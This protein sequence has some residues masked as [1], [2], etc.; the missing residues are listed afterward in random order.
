MEDRPLLSTFAVTSTDDA[1]PGSFRQAILDAESSSSHDTITFAIPGD[2]VQTIT[3]ATALPTITKS[4]LLDGWSQPG[5]AGTPLIELRGN[6]TIPQGLEITGSDVQVRG[7]A[8][9]GFSDGPAIEIAGPDAA[10]N[11]IYGNILGVDSSGTFSS[12]NGNGIVVRTGAHDNIIGSN[13]DGQNDAQE[14]NVIDGNSDTGI[15]VASG[16]PDDSAGMKLGDA[17]NSLALNGSASIEGGELQFSHVYDWQP[18]AGSAFTTEPVDITRFSSRFQFKTTDPAGGGFTFTIQRAGSQ[19]LGSA[20]GGLGYQGIVPSAAV[21][22]DLANDSGE[23]D[24]STGLYLDGAAPTSAGSIDL[25][26]TGIDLTSADVFEAVVSYDGATL[27]VTITDTQTGA[28]ASQSYP[29]DLVGTVG[30]ATA[31]VGFTGATENGTAHEDI[32]NWTYSAHAGDPIDNR[33][34]G[35]SIFG[36]GRDTPTPESELQFDGSN[37]VRLPDNLISTFLAAET[38]EGWFQTTEGGVILGYEIADPSSDQS[39][40][41][42]P[43]LYVGTDGKLYGDG[44]ISSP[45][46]VADGRWHQFALV[47]DRPSLTWTVYLD[48]Q[49]VGSGQGDWYSWAFNQ[50]GTGYTKYRFGTPN[51]NPWYGFQG[52]I[53]D[54]RIWSVERSADQIRKDMTTAASGTEPGLEAYYPF[55]EGQ[56]LTAHDA[57]P[58]HRDAT[59]ETFGGSDPAWVTTGMAP[60]IDLG[61]DGVTYPSTSPRQGPNRLQN[62]PVIASTDNHRI[63]G[64]LDGAAATTYHIEFFA[65]SGRNPGDSGDAEVFLQSIAA[66]TDNSGVALFDVPYT[67]VDGKPAISATATDPDGNTSEVSA[68]RRPISLDVAQD[69]IHQRDLGPI[70]FTAAAGTAV[71]VVDPEADPIPR[72]EL[73]LTASAGTLTLSGTAGLSGAG[74]G[75]GSLDYIGLASDLTAALE[76]M[77]F[78]PPPGF[79]GQVMVDISAALPGQ[80]PVTAR[81]TV[82]YGAYLVTTTADSGP[83]SLRQAILDANHAPGADTIAFAIA[84]DGVQTIQLQSELPAITDG[85]LLDGWSQPGFATAPLI[86]IRG[87]SALRYGLKITGSNV[88]VRGLAIDGFS[89]GAAVQIDGLGAS[90]DWIHG[91][92]LGVDPSGAFSLPNKNGIVIRGGAHDNTIGTTGAG[93]YDA[94]DANVIEGNTGTGVV[95]GGFGES[96]NGLALNGSA[97][98]QDGRIRLTDGAYNEAGSAFA[99]QPIDVTHFSTTFRFKLTNATAD[100]F[101]FTIQGNSASSLGGGASGLGYEGIGSSVAVKFDLFNNS[102]EGIDSTGLFVDGASPSEP[103]SID[104]SGTGIDLHSGAIFDATVN[105]DGVTLA[106]TIADTRTGA[107]A[108][109]S[110][111]VDIPGT[112]GGTTAYVG[113]TGGTGGAT[114]VQDILSWNGVLPANDPVNN[115]ITGNAIFDNGHDT[116]T[117]DGKLRF[118]GS[119][120]VSLPND[121]VR[122]YESAETVEAWFQT[123]T[124]GVILGYQTSDPSSYPYNGYVPAL[125]VGTDGRLYGELWNGGINQATS[126]GPVNDGRWHHVGLVVDGQAGTESLYLDGLLVGSVS[127]SAQNFGGSFD[128][129]GTG[130]TDGWPAAPGGWFGFQGQIDDVQIRSVVRSADEIQHD[131]STAATGTEPGL[132]AYYKFDEGQGATAFDATANHRDAALATTGTDLPA[133]VGRSGLAIDL[134]G[135]GVTYNAPAPRQGPNNL[136]NYPIVVATADGRYRGWLSGSLLDSAYHIEFFAGA[137]AGQAQDYL[138]SLEVTT[139]GA[140]QAVFDV[141]FAPPADEPVISAT[142]TDPSGNTS[143]ISEARR[144][145]VL[146]VAQS[147]FHSRDVVPI[148]FAAADNTAITVIDPDGDPLPSIELSVSA[149]A[150]TLTLSGTSRLVGSGNG[151]GALD[152]LGTASDL[153]AAL[154]GMRYEPPPGFTGQVTVSLVVQAQGQSPLA[155]ELTLGYGPYFVTTTADNGPGSLRQAILDANNAPGLD[156]IAFAIP[157]GG[158]QTITPVKELPAITDPVLIDGTSQPGYA[159]TPLIELRGQAGGAADGLTITGSG[160]T[161]RGLSIDGF[162]SGS[163][164]ILSGPSAVDN[165]IEANFIGVD[166]TGSHAEPN[167]HGVSISGG[168]HDNAIGGTTAGAGNLIA[169]DTGSG[170][171][172]TDA[173][174][175]GNSIVGNRIF[176]TSPDTPTPDGILR[177]DGSGS[178]V[179]VPPFPLG[180]A[181]TFEAWVESDNVHANFARIFDFGNAS[182]GNNIILFWNGGSGQMGLGDNDQYGNWNYFVTDQQFPERRRVYVAAVI[183]GQGSGSIYWDGQLIK[184]GSLPA[185]PTLTR[186]NQYLARSNWSSDSAFTG[187]MDEVRI[188]SAA[189][190]A[191]EIQDDGNHALSGDEPGLEAYYRFDEGQGTTAFDLTSHHR[192]ATLASNGGSLPTWSTEATLPAWAP[193]AIDLSGDGPTPNPIGPWQGPGGA[194]VRLDGSDYVSLP[195]DLIR[196]YRNAE[197]I[198]AWFQT[199]SGG[200]ILGYQGGSP[201]SGQP[202]G[203]VPALYVGTDGLLHGDLYWDGSQSPITSRGPVNDGAWHHVALVVDNS[204]PSQ[205][206][207]LDGARLGSVSNVVADFGGSFNQIGTGYTQYWPNTNGGWFGFRGQI[208]DV[209]IWSV[210][211]SADE[212]SQDMSAVATG[213]EPSL[214]A[215]YKFDEGQGTTDHD[216]TANHR[217]A[218]IVLPQ[219]PNHLQSYPIVV[220]TADG[221]YRGWLGGSLPDSSY[222]IEFFAGAAIG[223]AEVYLGSLEVTTDDS[224]QAAFDVPYLPPADKPFVSATA[225]DPEGN[226]SE[227]S[228]SPRPIALDVGQSK[229]HRR[230]A[231]AIPFTAADRSEIAVVDPDADPYPTVQLTV[232]ASAGTLTLSGTA[233]LTGTGNGT[234]ALQYV[235]SAADLDA[236]LAGMQLTPPPGFSGIVTVGVAVAADGQLPLTATLHLE[237]GPYFVTTTADSGPGSLRQAILDANAAPGLD[238]IAFAIAGSGVQTISPTTPL[239]AITDPLLID[240]YSQPGY[241]GTPLIELSGQAAGTGDGLTITASGS[242]IRGLAIDDFAGT[243]IVLSGADATGDAII[244]NDI[245]TDPSGLEARPNGLGIAI[246]GGAHDNTVGGTIADGNLISGNAGSGVVV[247]GDSSVGNRI[248]GNRIFANGHVTPTP[249]GALRFDGSNWVN[250]PN[251]LIDSFA[252]SET[253]EAWFQTQ[254]GGVILGYQTYGYPTYPSFGAIPALYVGTDG[255]LY[256]GFSGS[257]QIG[258]DRFVADGRWHHAALVVD[259]GTRTLSLYV[260]GQLV[261]SI[262]GTPSHIVAYV[263]QIGIGF[264]DSW[265]ATPGGWYGF[266]G[267]ID[268]VRIWSQARSAGEIQH[269]MTTAAK[270]TEPGLEL[271]YPF[272]VR[273]WTTALDATAHHRD[274]T[275]ASSSGSNPTWVTGSVQSIDLGGASIFPDGHEAL[276]FDGSGSYVQLPSFD[277]GGPFTVEAWVES[278]NVHASWARIIDFGEDVWHNSIAL[279][280]V[281]DTGVM[282]L[283][284]YDAAGAAYAITT[285]AVFPQGQWVHVAASI[286]SQGNAAIYW[287][288]ELVAAGSIGVPPVE[289]RTNQYVARSEYAPDSPFT[290]AIDELEIWNAARTADQIRADMT[291]VPSGSE[292]GLA[293]YYGFN[294]GARTIAHDAT[295]HHRDAALATNGGNLPT[296]ILA[297][298]IDQGADGVTYNAAAPRRGPNNLENYPIIATTDGGRLQGWLSGLPATTYHLEFFASAAHSPTGSGE[299]EVFLAATDVTSDG[300]GVAIFDIPYAP[301]EGRPWISATATDPLGNTS[302]VSPARRVTLSGLGPQLRFRQVA[303]VVFSTGTGRALDLADPDAGPVPTYAELTLSV[304]GGALTLGGT[305]GLSG[306]GNGTASLDYRGT[307]DDLNAALNGLRFDPPAAIASV[308]KFTVTVS[309]PG[310][311]ETQSATSVIRSGPWLVTNTND[312]GDG[313]L[314]W[315]I[316]QANADP[317]LDGIAFAIPGAGVQTIAPASPLPAI[318]DPLFL[319]GT[320]QPGYAGTPLIELSGQAAGTADGLTITGSGT[321]VRG[322]AIDDFASGA[323]I[324]LSGSSASGNVIASNVLGADLAGTQAAPNDYGIRILG[325]AHDNLIGGNDRADGNVI[326]YHTGPGIVVT[327]NDSVGNRIGGNKIYADARERPAGLS[328]DGSNYLRLPDNLIG[329]LAPVETFEARFRTN[330]GGVILGYQS[331]D[332]SAN[333]ASGWIPALFVGTDGRLYGSIWSVAYGLMSSS[334]AVNDGRWHTVALAVNGASQTQSLYL[335]GTLIG[336]GLGQFQD[337][338]GRFNQVGTGYTASYYHNTNSGWFGFHGQID[339]VRIWSVPRSAGDVQYDS[340]HALTGFEPGLEAYY[341]FDEGQGLTAHDATPNHRD[342]TLA[343]T[344]GSLP[345]WFGQA[346]DLG[347]DGVTA[348]ASAPRQGPNNLQNYPIVLTTADGRVRGWLGGSLPNAHYDLEFFASANFGAY[349]SGE[350]EVYLGA[351]EVTTDALGQAVFD[352]PYKAPAG[353]QIVTATA[354]DPNGDTSEISS[355]RE[356]KLSVS[357]AYVRFV[358][359]S[360]VALSPATG[361]ALVLEDPGAGPLDPAWDLSLSVASGSLTLATTAGLSGTG[362]GTGSLHY[363]GGL[364]ELN[365]ALDGLWFTPAADSPGKVYLSIAAQSAGARSLAGRVVLTDGLCSVTTTAN[366]GEGSLRQAIIDAI[367]TPGAATIGFAIAGPGAQTISPATPLPILPAGLVIDGTTQPGYAGTPLIELDGQSAG[368]ADGLT[369]MR[370]GITIRGLAIDDFGSGA[371]ILISGP[372]ATGDLIE[373]NNIGTDPT[374]TLPKPNATGITIDGNARDNTIGGTSAAAGNLI[375]FNAGS[376]IVVV[377]DSSVGNRILGNRI[378][379]NSQAQHAGL[380]FDGSAAFVQLP[381]FPLGGAMTFEEWVS[382]DNVSAPWSRIFDFSDGPDNHEIDLAWQ[383]QTGTMS[384]GIQDQNDNWSG[385]TTSNV[386][387]QNRWVHVA[388]TID[389]QGNAVLYWDGVDEA[390]GL[391][392]VPPVLSRSQMYLGWSNWG[393]LTFAGGIHD[394]AIWSG[395]RTADQIKVDMTN[396]PTGSEPGLEAYYPLDD[397]QGGIA[398]DA[399]PNHRDAMLGTQSG[400]SLPTWREIP[401]QAIDLNGDGFTTNSPSPR[402]GPNNLQNYPVVVTTA[403]G[404]FQGWLEGSQPDARY[405]VDFFAS[406]GYARWGAGEA[407]NY[408]GSL[409][410]TTDSAGQ[411]VF[412]VPYT[413][414]ADQPVVTATA[415]DPSGNT[416]ELSARRRNTS[417]KAPTAYI[418]VTPGSSTALAAAPGDSIALQDPEAGP[419][420]PVWDLS[421]SVAAGTLSFSTMAGLVGTGNGTA[422]LHYRGGLIELNA[423]LAGLEFTAPP[424]FHGTISLLVTA[425]PDGLAPIESQLSL[426]DGEFSVTTT[427]DSGP[428]SL[429]QAILDADATG[430]SA[431]ITFGIPGTGAQTITLASP[432]PAITGAVLIDGTSQPG[433]AGTPL[434]ELSGRNAGPSD[435]IV[436]TGSSATI[437]GLAI[438][439]FISGAGILITGTAATGNAIGANFIG[440]DSSGT[441]AQP[442]LFGVEMSDG[443]HDNTIGGTAAGV[444]N[445]IIDNLGSEVA[446]TGAGSVRNRIL[447]NRIFAYGQHPLAGVNFDGSGSYVQL[448]SFPLGGPMTVEAWVESDNVHAS[449]ARVLDFGVPYGGN[450]ILFTWYWTTGQMFWG[451]NDQSG[452]WHN[453]LTTAVFPQGRWVYVAATVDAEGNG[454]IYWDGQQ[455]ASG[456]VG[457]APVESRPDQYLARSNWSY[458]SAF[459]GS[460]DEVKIWSGARTPD[461]I[462]AD[463][464]ATPSGSDPNLVAY[465]PLDEGAGT[466]VHDASGNQ[467]DGAL[468][469]I[470]ASNPVWGTTTDHAIDLVGGRPTARTPSPPQGTNNPQNA[471]VIVTTADGQLQGWLSGSLPSSRYHIELF[472]SAGAGPDGSGEAEAYL[473]SLEVTT[474]ATGQAVFDIPFTAPADKPIVSAT[475]TDPSGNTSELS[476]LRQA[477]V[478]QP[479]RTL[480]PVSGTDLVFS[481]ATGDPFVLADPDAGPLGALPA[482]ELSLSVSDGALTLSGTTGLTGTGNGTDS[483][484]YQGTIPALN[485]ALDGLRYTREPGFHGLATLSLAAHSAD[486][487]PLEGKL[488]IGF[489]QVTSTADGGPG[490]LRQAILDADASASLGTIEFD[491]PGTGVHTIAPLLPLPP[492]TASELIDGFTQPGYSGTP[493]VELSG[494]TVGGGDGLTIT[495]SGAT[496]RGLAIDGFTAGSAIVISGPGAFGNVIQANVLGAGLVGV[497]AAPNFHGVQIEGGAHDNTVGGTGPADGNLIADDLGSGVVVTGTG[498]ADDRIEGNRIFV[499]APAKHAGLEFDGSGAFV[500]L[501]SFTLGGPVTLEAS[502]ESDDIQAS[503]TRIFNFGDDPGSH[504]LLLTWVGVSGKMAL[505]DEGTSGWG[506][507][508]TSSV[509]PQGRW[510]HVAATIDT[511]GDGVIY[512]NGVPVASGPV[513]VPLALS[514]SRMYLGRS[515]YPADTPFAGAMHDVA[516]WSDARTAD[517][518]RNDMSNP[519]SGSEP[520]LVAYYPLNEEQGRTLHDF[521]SNHYDATLVAGSGN[522]PNWQALGAREI[523]FGGGE[524]TPSA[525]ASS[526]GPNNLQNYPVVLTTADG[527]LRGWLGA[528][529]PN[530][531]Y[532]LEFFAG[533]EPGQA[534]ILLGSLEVTTDASGQAVF[535]VPFVPPAG[536]PVVSATATDPSGDTSEVSGPRRPTLAIPAQSVPRISGGSLV[537]SAAT[538]NAFAL[539]DPDAGPLDPTWDLSLSVDAGTLSLAGT[540]GLSGT[541]DGTDSL[542]Y[543]GTLAALNT[544]L[545]GLRYTW[546]AGFAGLATVSGAARSDGATTLHGQVV[547]DFLPVTTTA[548]S[549]PGSLR[550]AITDADAATTPAVI[551]F[552]IPGG[553][554]H[555]I[556]PLTPLPP[557]S[558][559]VLIDGFSQPGYT[560][561][562]LI[563]LDGR[564]AGVSE[565]LT[566]AGTNVAFSGLAIDGFAFPASGPGTVKI[567]SGPLPPPGSAGQQNGVDIYRFDLATDERLVARVRAR[568][569]SA[570]LS[571]VD[572]QGRLLVQ[573]DGASSSSQDA[574]IDQHL[575]AGTYFLT[576]AST[577][578]AGDYALSASLAPASAPFQPIN[579]GPRAWYDQNLS[580]TIGDFNGD[581]IPDLA[582]YD[583]VHLGRGDGTF[584]PPRAGLGIPYKAR[585]DTGMI[586]GEFDGDGKL[587]LAVVDSQDN[588]VWVLLGNGDGTFRQAR[589]YFVGQNPISLG[590]GDFDG[591]GT[592]DLAVVNFT[593]RDISVLLG[594]GDGT[595]KPEQRIGSGGYLPGVGSWYPFIIAPG[596]FSGHSKL[597]LVFDYGILAGNGDGTFQFKGFL[598]APAF[599]WSLAV[600]DF[601]GD[602]RLDV[603]AALAG[604]GAEYQ[605]GHLVAVLLGNGDGTFQPAQILDTGSGSIP[606]SVVAGD[607][608]GDGKLDL[609]IADAGTG[610]ISVFL[611]NGDGTFQPERR[612]AAGVH[613]AN[614]FEFIGPYDTLYLKAADF[615]RDGT[616]DLAVYDGQGK[617]SVLLGNGDGTFREPSRVDTGSNPV[618]V[619]AG[620]FNRDG[621]LDLAVANSGSNDV[622][623]LLGNGDGTFQPEVRYAAGNS[624]GYVVTADFN[625]DG[626]P[627]LAVANSGSGD[628]S[629][630]LGR[631]DGTFLPQERYAVGGQPKT[632]MVADV[633]G[634]GRP[635]LVVNPGQA[636]VSVLLNNGDGTFRV[637]RRPTPGTLPIGLLPGD[638]DGNA[639]LKL[640]SA[641]AISQNFWDLNG[642]GRPDRVTLNTASDDLSVS[643][644]QGD[645]TYLP[646]DLLTAARYANPIVADFNG[647]GTDDVCELNA[648]GDILYRQGRPSQPGT[649]DPPVKINP[650]R[651]ARDLVAVKTSSGLIL[652]AVDD[653]GDHVS[654]YQFTTRGF[655]PVGSLATGRL[656]AQIAA[657]DLNGDGLDDLVVRNAGDG[658][659]SIFLGALPSA[660]NGYL[661]G[662]PPFLLSA[663]LPVGLGVSDLTL[664]DTTG[665]GMIDILVTNKLTGQVSVLRNT[666][667]GTFAPPA[668]YRAG[669][670]VSGL[671]TT[672]GDSVVTSQDATEGVAAGQFTRGG[673]TGLVT[674]N[675]GSKTLDL[676]AGLGG[677]RFANPV[678][679]DTNSGASVVRVGDFDRDGT[680]DLAILDSHGLSVLLSDGKGGF[681]SP[682]HYDAGQDPT[683]LTIADVNRDGKLDLVVGNSYGDVLVLLGKGDGSFQPWRKADQSITL[684]VADLTGN[685][686]KDIIY[687]DKGLDRVV[688]DYGGGQSTVVGDRSSGLLSPGA[689]KLADLNGDGIPDLIVANSGSNNI[690]IYPGLGN[691]QFGPALNGGHGFFTGTNP[692][693]V[694]VADINGDGKPDLLVANAGSNDVSVFLGVGTGTSW[695]LSPGPRIKTDAGPTDLAVGNFLGTGRLDL[696]V[697]NQD[698]NN[699]QIFPGLGGGFFNDQ[700]PR[701]FAV[702]S[703]PGQLIV[704][705]FDGKPDLL[706]VNAGSNDLTLISNF[707]SPDFVT[708]T[709]PSGGQDPVTAFAFNSG[710]G[711]DDLVVANNADGALALFEGGPE[712]LTLFSTETMPELPSPTALAFAALSGGQIQFY[713]ATEGREAAVLVELSLTGESGLPSAASALSPS[714]PEN[715]AQLV[716]V[717]ESSLALVGSLLIVTLESPASELSV[718]SAEIAAATGTGALAAGP[719][720]VGQSLVGRG[721]NGLG[722]GTGDLELGQSEQPSA[723]IAPAKTISWERFVLGID[724]A[725]ERY[726]REHQEK[727]P[728]ERTPGRESSPAPK[729]H[730]AG[731]AAPADSPVTDRILPDEGQRGEALDEAIDL[732]FHDAGQGDEAIPMDAGWGVEVAF[733][734]TSK[735]GIEVSRSSSATAEPRVSLR[736]ALGVGPQL[737]SDGASASRDQESPLGALILGAMAAAW[738]NDGRSRRHSKQAQRAAQQIAVR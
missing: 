308:V 431:T 676:L 304:S 383:N 549:G 475:A 14:A 449:W 355:V 675:P 225:T 285:D 544:A 714:I 255:K 7:L 335:D 141:P 191:D 186:P 446:V 60:A 289:S 509:F 116:P 365:V 49:S 710:S 412:D 662:G 476:R 637:L 671:D 736:S 455:V 374:G 310:L 179:Q 314:R 681:L 307:V 268:E 546:P 530:S 9:D 334:F 330:T 435:G 396:P 590:A 90:H 709:I 697:T 212:I 701:T 504:E 572:A 703:Q 254:S 517:Q 176:A 313:S 398:H 202:N 247:T 121:L 273:S 56:G 465:Y 511:Q 466:I 28:T 29:L 480:P 323:A 275:L 167:G 86:E 18:G 337:F 440:T 722:E 80:A 704:G 259:G 639:W 688:V 424:G 451:M 63:K 197:T 220:T 47:T 175:V 115:R 58:N 641:G 420:D 618:S 299:A 180:G 428:G 519:P 361:N 723:A 487:M 336:S 404:R 387:P 363:H 555:T 118:D 110:Y 218:T 343:T 206:L 92:V 11:W 113:F 16:N 725:L 300:S 201:D 260:D 1:G 194:G 231:V 432:L 438:G 582:A 702:G 249:K 360:A 234:G 321:T 734:L 500:Q 270:G 293:A 143:E 439:G 287:D 526:Q 117:P 545:E 659:L 187:A 189:R 163:G 469:T 144:P 661:S 617:I 34:N 183:D 22:F 248:L 123:T 486:A 445:L 164:I 735:D 434:I 400:G 385:I 102:G 348:N 699:V 173:N 43:A 643:L 726:D 39:C 737:G 559:T 503:W 419:L 598:N 468:A 311:E 351:L 622:S 368:S 209:R 575:P 498:T 403:D 119:N 100:G 266:Q 488:S 295:A 670:G 390:S 331:S 713:A 140:G 606:T 462:R 82:E 30:A 458:D 146:D 114:A 692:V 326:V 226:T 198:E 674:I 325:G 154:A 208:D 580:F 608:N 147:R 27:A 718:S 733:R 128:Q 653:G 623:V 574:L 126:N 553:G 628:V 109:Q 329:N 341:R 258:S 554:P 57:T 585:G 272:E 493:L 599:A 682:V 379:A 650:G 730:K 728:S 190:T 10:H 672:S 157:G 693:A 691:G 129:I 276:Q 470:G 447:G 690:L 594:N 318:T 651:P 448:P 166:P 229:F 537:F 362:N 664:A 51:N 152:Y 139:D 633:D 581:G 660:A 719:S 603:A 292:P 423:A 649:F 394:V 645:G 25:S 538:N 695:T 696:A 64:W 584:A 93:Q 135:D 108:S 507:L 277:L 158:V 281:A 626:R 333:P 55:D 284:W 571:L 409:D 356:T 397:G 377:G 79:S 165:A 375:A 278:D 578:G 13:D 425:Q 84:G 683:G 253:I 521:G 244:A 309:L 4:V 181:I 153:A 344:G 241:A 605:N 646:A 240:G 53:D 302:E 81:L 655:I 625:G 411:A 246:S 433:Y 97:S 700:N 721:E 502:V 531:R 306:S 76:G 217:D 199:T 95:V 402:Q 720:A 2:G 188:W 613:S 352:V 274:G 437:R 378:F 210:A 712:G 145:V 52:Q 238:T 630:L 616:L 533:S 593:S 224:G 75:T 8:I 636:D 534:D 381:S 245:G 496:V 589:E 391:V 236:A 473:G 461:Q 267:Q 99:A 178:Y 485:A 228:E 640:V 94:Q 516:I 386:F 687:A 615:D 564:E 384:L 395:A 706:T 524:P 527:R 497:Q 107:R 388:V 542:H 44:N 620:D 512:W 271:Y 262:P 339:D 441:Q 532:H 74:N 513:V 464:T 557:V 614:E 489:F 686:S 522:A 560:G 678:A 669:T 264:T 252:D 619:A 443:A 610:D 382:S 525:T 24:D 416:S 565:S 677:G 151:A 207:Y 171:G 607:F 457:A 499:N 561:T 539:A 570:E 495:G 727:A 21:K 184:T 124:G 406:H 5:F 6:S 15:V 347:G 130:Q 417:L 230:D 685:G 265:P 587:D 588:S 174:S 91:N 322:L 50:I 573:S 19:A 359:G 629:V 133:W 602:G 604:T 131:M 611:G 192:D 563:S 392:F 421:L 410:V 233:G 221:R 642:D 520:D 632:L 150:G 612:F 369:I 595:F 529:L 656:P 684:A 450:N 505:I 294:E 576:V 227:L 577:G 350:A 68:P 3:L 45:G 104:L 494:L 586:A 453:I 312:S 568:G 705:S 591:D 418:R 349:G 373:A 33:I 463:V 222:H 316:E 467:Q 427:A 562:P 490:T 367:A 408:L 541:G 125:Y 647:D 477:T 371:G 279:A 518:I 120:Y 426:A 528:S 112:V 257:G 679:I 269:D 134:G 65:S 514:R 716:P 159:G 346:I 436:I 472:A 366:S 66:T 638:F 155:A 98:I 536:E 523:D 250:L 442:D 73:T 205:T 342:A 70:T 41:W 283:Y 169:D 376:G 54:V 87:Q 149:W 694:T 600:G 479:G 182:G 161:V 200:V 320:T 301:V 31:Y 111:T 327:G 127:G 548:D 621:R 219:G 170:V 67:P 566:I 452:N 96:D 635:D 46:N 62:Y 483:L 137:L 510:V 105:Y 261:Q 407:Q 543:R 389:G 358:P 552:A 731:S 508:E 644:G 579:L 203:W 652:A 506:F 340:T 478:A 370:S 136:Q 317:G 204:A 345:A 214:E 698:A 162:T 328:F 282:R 658:T 160:S 393:D 372:A 515:S 232:S 547:L 38:I 296:W 430:T 37:Y 172:V 422:A 251:Y 634:D 35:N 156:T 280:W 592:L 680:S 12:P 242:T 665:R 492:I 414:P 59:L 596:A 597:D 627:D 72:V 148:T 213:T 609:A 357:S 708:I 40:C 237:Y 32:L 474:D 71:A 711:F 663:T 256:G 61:G 732:L 380:E 583:G 460:I 413:L 101:T 288:G 303:P 724:E 69:R 668:V 501:P 738:A 401:A 211:R 569:I 122:G 48:G 551:T 290:G 196:N 535:D 540:A 648:A 481:E 85:V 456:Y 558:G 185:P 42:T 168:A 353:K 305:A 354:T 601:N 667:N 338:G 567:E 215:Y 223:Q 556:A 216:V 631:G 717:S 673:S 405:H 666:G 20:F 399:T 106:V 195:N 132:E 78:D 324:V 715:V 235:G 707:T 177:L 471:P 298:R 657:A 142:A 138:G 36:N 286:D 454:A 26:G 482:W 83:G 315:A 429:R 103:G 654:L 23:G 17:V 263:N 77:R 689:V 491:I 364:S 89:S 484:H 297:P 319:D 88:I 239:P 550:Q 332:P 291:A 243:A 459:T 193:L 415:T 624:P 444:G 729:Q